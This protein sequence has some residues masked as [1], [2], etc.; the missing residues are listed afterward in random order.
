MESTRPC[1]PPQPT[2]RRNSLSTPQRTRTALYKRK[3]L[4]FGLLAAVCLLAAGGS[5][6]KWFPSATPAL[7]TAR[8]LAPEDAIRLALDHL[9]WHNVRVRFDSL[10]LHP[11]ADRPAPLPVSLKPGVAP[12]F[13]NVDAEL[14]GVEIDVH[15]IVFKGTAWLANVFSPRAQVTVKLKAGPIALDKLESTHPELA[16]IVF[17]GVLREGQL[18]WMTL[19]AQAPLRETRDFASLRRSARAKSVF[20]INNAGFR[21]EKKNVRFAVLHGK[22]S[23][24]HPAW[25]HELKGSLYQGTLH[26]KGKTTLDATGES[27]RFD[28]TFTLEK[29]QLA[30]A[31]ALKSPDWKFLRGTVSGSVR[32][33]GGLPLDAKTEDLKALKSSGTLTAK[34]IFINVNHTRHQWEEATLRVVEG[35]LLAPE[36]KVEIRNLNVEGIPFQKAR[37]LVRASPEAVTLSE[38]KLW[39]EHGEIDFSGN[40]APPAKTYHLKLKGSQLRAEDFLKTAVTGPAQFEG[41]FDG[42][43][44]APQKPKARPHFARGLSGSLTLRMMEG[45]IEKVGEM[46]KLLTVLNLFSRKEQ[47]KSRLEF[48]RLGGDFNIKNGLVATDNLALDGP[49]LTLDVKG[50]TDLPSGKVQAKVKA[51]PLKLIK[52]MANALPGLDKWLKNPKRKQPLETHFKVTGSLEDPKFKL[53]R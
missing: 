18:E 40:Y 6:E 3:P 50:N 36:G 49:Q 45:S 12:A 52:D 17:P 19:N 10:N 53:I 47:R 1:P 5:L 11:A 48:N 15:G 38:G 35:P 13:P 4:F 20:K 16:K 2:H 31:D 23:W 25:T 24:A 22:A 34:R 42:S 37:T 33:H 44:N 7:Q 14:K 21:V 32:V 8:T 46:E 29:V 27:A 28:S 51:V 30:R 9:G 41:V 43:L 39:P 26:S